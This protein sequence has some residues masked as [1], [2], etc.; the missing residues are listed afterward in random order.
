[1]CRHLHTGQ[2]LSLL[3]GS[4]RRSFLPWCL[5][6]GDWQSC[7]QMRGT[8]GIICILGKGFH[9]YRFVGV[10][11][12]LPCKTQSYH[13]NLR[14][15]KALE[16]CEYPVQDF[17]GIFCTLPQPSSFKM[18]CMCSV[19]LLQEKYIKRSVNE[20]AVKGNCLLNSQLSAIVLHTVWKKKRKKKGTFQNTHLV[21]GVH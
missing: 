9:T 11:I 8:H 7:K 17:F 19:S 2:G 13:H 5:F 20:I 18:M 6:S 10:S 14:N 1:M 3:F 21:T 16:T 12:N 4:Y 15:W